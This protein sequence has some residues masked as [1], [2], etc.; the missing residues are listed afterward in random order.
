MK[1]FSEFNLKKYNS[2]SVSSICNKAYFPENEEDLLKVFNS[3]N[4]DSF[5]VLGNGNNVIFSKSYYEEAFIIF[6]DCFNQIKLSGN[7]VE[8]EAGATTEQFSEFALENSLTGAEFLFDI[9]SSIGG[10][11]FMNAGTLEG[12]TKSILLK[13]RYLNLES[14]C[15]EEKNVKDISLEYRN[16]FFQLNPKLIITKC[17]FNLSTGDR[18]IIKEKMNSSRDRR[19]KKQPREF[20]NGGSV[21]KRPKG[22]YVGPMIEKLGLKGVS[23]GGASVSKK[24]AGF[25]VNSNEASG[26]DIL[27]LIQ[28]IQEKVK[29]S[30]G[31]TL[32]VEQRI[33]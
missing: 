8:I 33:I 2:Y 6:N 14:M 24:H 1:V 23:I 10:A 32:E 15:F 17:W 26:R 18:V 30:F 21:F 9:P 16:S 31:V 4:G 3:L 19:W 28:L 12:E 29:E 7:I 27:G 13:V 20:P 11:V 5:V 25:I 22:M